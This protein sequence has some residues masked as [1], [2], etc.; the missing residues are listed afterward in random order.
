MALSTQLGHPVRFGAEGPAEPRP[1]TRDLT[2]PARI[3]R[4]RLLTAEIYESSTITARW[5]RF[6][7]DI[8]KSLTIDVPFGEDLPPRG[9]ERTRRSIRKQ[10]AGPRVQ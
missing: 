2:V 8:G 9:M 5:H 10:I 6:S 4:E 3:L 7:A 1:R